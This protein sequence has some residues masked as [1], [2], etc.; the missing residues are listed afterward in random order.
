MAR[1]GGNPVVP[2]DRS[3]S[4]Y[5]RATLTNVLGRRTLARGN[6]AVTPR[7]RILLVDDHATVRHGLKLMLEGEPDLEVIAE[8]SDGAEALERA[9]N[10][11]ADVI[12]MDLSMPGTSGLVATRRLKE[13][14]PEV[15]IVTLTR[16][17]DKTYLQELLRAGTG[18]YVLKKSPHHELLRAIRAV[19]A[20][21]QYID[22]ALTHHLAAPFSRQERARS[23]RVSPITDR[24]SQVLRLVSRGHS[25]KE[26]A[27]QLGLSVKTIELHKAN[28]MQKLGLQGRIELLRYAL[29]NGWL[30]DA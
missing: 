4:Y 3:S 14:R 26:I 6:D 28:A 30:Q 29:H 15:A 22:P 2:T 12:V 10:V 23:S 11:P 17:A 13:V 7:L 19:A 9:R 16:H 20:G 5:G 25:N 1:V 21:Q 8:A 24:E 27:A 18:G